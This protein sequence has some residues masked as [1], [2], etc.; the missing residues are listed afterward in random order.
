M[1]YAFYDSRH[2]RALDG[3]AR[4]YT[5]HRRPGVSDLRREGVA[6]PLF[7]RPQEHHADGGIVLVL[8]PVADVPLAQV[9]HRWNNRVQVIQ[10]VDRDGVDAFA[11]GI[12]LGRDAADV[13]V[14]VAGIAVDADAAG[15]GRASTIKLIAISA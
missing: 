12:A 1:C 5:V 10:A 4:Q 11:E 9:M 2:T 15:P 7:Q 14:D 13:D 3:R 6:Q 8:H